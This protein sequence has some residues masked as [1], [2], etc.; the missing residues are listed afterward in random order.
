MNYIFPH[1][2]EKTNSSNHIKI[3][4]KRRQTPNAARRGYVARLFFSMPSYANMVV[5]LG[6]IAIATAPMPKA[7]P[8]FLRQVQIAMKADE[9]IISFESPRPTT[10]LLGI[11]SESGEKGALRRKRIRRAF[12]MANDPRFCSLE[13]YMDQSEESPNEKVCQVSYT[14]IIG[15]GGDHRPLD[16][17][18]NEPLVVDTNYDGATEYD[19][20][21]T[22]LNIQEMEDGFGKSSSWLKYAASITEEYRI[23]Y[24]SKVDLNTDLSPQLLIQFINSELPIAPFNRYTYGG[25]GQL[26]YVF[27][28]VY[29]TGAFYFMSSDLA[30]YIGHVLSGMDRL[31]ISSGIGKEDEIMGSFIHVNSNPIKFMDLS[32]IQLWDHSKMKKVVVLNASKNFM[33]WKSI[34]PL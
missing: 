7:V 3:A 21:Y 28:A 34:C 29:G 11:F 8:R 32:N 24:V 15:G 27:D 20:D 30:Y 16:H 9:S 1:Q 19:G 10:F 17:D 4:P 14:F 25:Y 26:S 33:P 12:Q 2:N 13:E 22:Y 18:D 31:R 23:D 6:F 5:V